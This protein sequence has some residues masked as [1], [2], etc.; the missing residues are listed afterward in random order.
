MKVLVNQMSEKDIHELKEAFRKIDKNN[1]GL[2]GIEDLRSAMQQS[3][4]QMEPKVL[5]HIFKEVSQ[6]NDGKL[7][8]RYT[9][10]I[11]ATLD[12]RIYLTKEKLWSL[13]K[14]FDPNNQNFISAD[15]L[16]EI[17]KRQ[18][19]NVSKDELIQLINEAVPNHDGKITFN[20][21]VKIM[22]D[23]V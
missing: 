8:I 19:K 4:F 1:T 13:F 23:D 9:E 14:Y 20:D 11:T 22:K 21:F 6:E 7:Y 12:L 5:E 3:G 15:D 18:G 16:Q 10:F 2:I 17:F